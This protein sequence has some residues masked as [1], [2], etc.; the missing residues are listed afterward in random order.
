MAYSIRFYVNSYTRRSQWEKPTAPAVAQIPADFVPL[1][2]TLQYSRQP[3]GPSFLDEDSNNTYMYSPSMVP[4]GVSAPVAPMGQ[5][6]M[7]L[8]TGMN[9]GPGQIRQPSMQEIRAMRADP[10]GKMVNASDDRIPALLIQNQLAQRQAH[11]L[12]TTNQLSLMNGQQPQA[13]LNYDLRSEIS[14]DPSNRAIEPEKI[15]RREKKK[16][17][18]PRSSIIDKGGSSFTQENRPYPNFRTY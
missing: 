12:N 7:Q 1:E 13:P 4:P 2:S 3:I 16:R 18:K 8:Q 5:N 9:V 14:E 11:R 10:N 6:L 17:S 15:R